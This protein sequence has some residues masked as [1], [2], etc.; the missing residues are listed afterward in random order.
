MT[1][2]SCECKSHRGH[3]I[4]RIRT[5]DYIYALDRLLDLAQEETSV[6][7]IGGMLYHSQE[8]EDLYNL[9]T[10]ALLKVPSDNQ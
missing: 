8:Y 7:E 1:E 6:G 5:M 3:H 4:E 10:S 9:L 2:M